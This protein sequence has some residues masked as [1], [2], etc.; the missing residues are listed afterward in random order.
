MIKLSEDALKFVEQKYEG[1]YGKEIMIFNL[2]QEKTLFD[3]RI[4]W[5]AKWYLSYTKSFHLT[6]I[7][8]ILIGLLGIIFEINNVYL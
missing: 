4:N 5:F 3:R 2:E 8:F 7:F 1:K 6:F